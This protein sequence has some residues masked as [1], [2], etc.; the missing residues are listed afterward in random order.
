MGFFATLF[1][2]MLRDAQRRRHDRVEIA[3]VSPERQSTR[4]TRTLTIHEA[5]NGQY[6]E[7]IR[8]KYNPNGPDEYRREVYLV[9]DNEPLVDAISTVLVLGEK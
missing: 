1:D 7:F 3:S 8:H 2:R 4:P 5:V 9:R 6:I